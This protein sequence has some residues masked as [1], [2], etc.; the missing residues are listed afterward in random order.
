[1]EHKISTKSIT[2]SVRLSEAEADFLSELKIPDAKT[3]SDKLRSIIQQYRLIHESEKDYS[4]SLSLL[5]NLG[6]ASLIKLLESERK[7]NLSSDL[8]SKYSSWAAESYAYFI[9]AIGSQETEFKKETLT[10]IEEGLAQRVFKLI[11]WTLRMGV[12]EKAPCYNP[13]LISQNIN[14][15]LELTEI[16]KNKQQSIEE[17]EK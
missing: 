12:T 16:I 10:E 9:T 13:N 8:I 2:M 15:V 14:T 6:E 17:K 3:P 5:K 4:Q 7:N 11:E 1:M